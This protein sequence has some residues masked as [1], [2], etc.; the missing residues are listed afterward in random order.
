[1]EQFIGSVIGETYHLPSPLAGEAMVRGFIHFDIILRP[2]I[3][4]RSRRQNRFDV[5]RG[6]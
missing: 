5:G 1:M 6:P 3:V 2:S 4:L